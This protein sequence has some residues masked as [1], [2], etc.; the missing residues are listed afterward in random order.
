[1]LG[2]LTAAIS[3]KS[4]PVA[5]QMQGAVWRSP[6]ALRVRTYRVAITGVLSTAFRVPHASV[7]P[8]VCLSVQQWKYELHYYIAHMVNYLGHC[9]SMAA[10][11]AAFLLFLALR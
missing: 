7:C 11:M 4:H 3:T 9:V 5:N 10:L 2:G 1:M 6:S 8:Y